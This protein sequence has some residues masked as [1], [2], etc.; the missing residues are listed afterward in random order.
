M[1]TLL[2]WRFEKNKNLRRILLFILLLVEGILHADL[3]IRNNTRGILYFLLLPIGVEGK[4]SLGTNG[5]EAKAY[6]KDHWKDLEKIP[7]EAFLKVKKDPSPYLILGFYV[8]PERPAFPLIRVKVPSMPGE[9]AFTIGESDVW[10]SSAGESLFLYPWDIQLP[11]VPI[12][13]DNRYLDWRKI[14]ELKQFPTQFVPQKVVRHKGGT[15]ETIPFEK[16]KTWPSKGT[17]VEGLKLL[18]GEDAVYLMISSF[19]PMELGT[20]YWFYLISPSSPS[21]LAI[22]IP[23]VGKGGPI[24]LW[25]SSIEK[26]VQIGTFV[27]DLFVLEGDLLSR[28]LPPEAVP[29]VQ[30]TSKVWMSVSVPTS[31][32]TE[33]F[34]LTEFDLQDIP[35]ESG[36]SP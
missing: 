6:L 5:E 28:Y 34:Y 23:I 33:E 29:L 17:A 31:D 9:P 20:S 3:V 35:Y 11:K 25:T 16:A 22:E 27:S 13:I 26:P 18:R 32:G 10:K 12:Q 15:A 8:S 1:M 36:I 14:G 7:P 21:T 4:I 30:Q 2:S 24:L 19:S